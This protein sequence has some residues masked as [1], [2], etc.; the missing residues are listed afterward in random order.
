MVSGAIVVAWLPLFVAVARR[1]YLLLL[2]L[3]SGCYQRGAPG[4]SVAGRSV[5]MQMLSLPFPSSTLPVQ[6]K[7]GIWKVPYWSTVYKWCTPC[8]E[9]GEMAFKCGIPFVRWP[10][11]ELHTNQKSTKESHGTVV[12]E[13]WSIFYQ[14]VLLYIM[15]RKLLLVLITSTALQ[16][17]VLPVVR[18][19]IL[20]YGNLALVLYICTRSTGTCITLLDQEEQSRYLRE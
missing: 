5:Q 10:S 17:R 14:P 8:H 6:C 3:S 11:L 18:Y 19:S 7:F 13:Y 20:Q 9:F 1:C 15:W 12:Q 4:E 2:L 16:K